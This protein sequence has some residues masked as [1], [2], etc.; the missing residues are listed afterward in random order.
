MILKAAI[1]FWWKKT[2]SVIKGGENS[3]ISSIIVFSVLHFQ[4]FVEI[5]PS[6]KMN[7]PKKP[8]PYLK[9]NAN[10]MQIR[11]YILTTE[12]IPLLLL[13]YGFSFTKEKN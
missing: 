7:V 9:V 4:F 6:L 3:L 5:T 8:C 2:L 12:I 1:A 13:F 10:S 11:R